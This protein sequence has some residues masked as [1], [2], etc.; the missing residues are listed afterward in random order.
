[1]SYKY[2]ISAFGLYC[3]KNLLKINNEKVYNYKLLSV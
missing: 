1:M 2:K 3:K